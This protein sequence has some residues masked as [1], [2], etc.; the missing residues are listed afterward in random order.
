MKRGKAIVGGGGRVKE[1]FDAWDDH[2]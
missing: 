2:V 1:L